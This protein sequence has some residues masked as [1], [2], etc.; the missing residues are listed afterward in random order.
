MSRHKQEFNGGEWVFGWDQPLRTFYVQKY[1]FSFP[2]DEQIRVWLGATGDSVMYEVDDL[3][4]AA[5]KHGL[6][7]DYAMQMTLYGDKDEGI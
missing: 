5:R 7:I 2:E 6:F 1:D 3:V 4:R